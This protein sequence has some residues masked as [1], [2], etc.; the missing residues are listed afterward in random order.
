MRFSWIAI[1]L[2][3][4]ST[5]KSSLPD[6]NNNNNSDDDDDDDDDI[7]VPRHRLA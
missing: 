3:A 7:P 1:A 6:V 5:D 2:L 4:S